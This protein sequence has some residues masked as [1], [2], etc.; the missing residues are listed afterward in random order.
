MTEHTGIDPRPTLADPDDDP[1]RWLEEVE[2]ED[3]LAWVEAQNLATRAAYAD[4]LFEADRDALKAILDRPDNIPHVARR[5]DWLYNFW[6]DGANPRGIWRRTTMAEFD[7]ADPDWHIL[8]DLDALAEKEKADWIWHGASTRPGSHD[9]AILRLSTGGSDAVALREFDI[10]AGHFIED[11]FNLPPAKSMTHW[12]DRD[13]LLL[14]T[15]MGD[16][17]ATQS[18]YARTVR[19]WRH[20]Q[21]LADAAVIFEGQAASV[22]VGAHLSR[23]SAGNKIWL[24][25]V[26]SFFEAEIWLADK[27]GPRQKLDIP[28]DAKVKIH[29]DWLVVKPRHSWQTGGTEIPADTVVG[30]SLDAFLSGE[31]SFQV[32]FEPTE[33]RIVQGFT[34]FSDQL[35]VSI[36]DDLKPCF[37]VWTPNK[38]GWQRKEIAG[39]SDGGTANIWP[40]DV[41]ESESNGELLLM[42]Q[43]PVTPA[44]LAKLTVDGPPQV[45]KRQPPAFDATGLTVSR[46]EVLAADGTAIPYL[47][48]GPADD[49]LAGQAPVHLYG[50][51]GFGVSLLPNYRMTIGKLWLE[52]GGTSVIAN[53]RGGGEFGSA[54]HELGRHEGKALSHDDFAAVAKD[55]VDRGVTRPERIAAEG[56]SNGGLLITNMLTRHPARFGALFCT[57]PLVDMRRY[58][59]LLAGASWIDEY[60]DPDKPEDWAYLQNISAYHLARPG[61]GY[62]PILLAT[63][64]RDDRVH[65][66]HARKMA[67]KLQALGYDSAFYEPE[68][69]GHGYGKDNAETAAFVAL[70]YRF[71]RQAIG[72]ED[73]A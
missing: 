48:V 19:L 26:K 12:L 20:G 34:W 68:A 3:A 50:Y 1:F 60:G 38:E 61:E 59:K 18:G 37:E 39:L 10:E 49:P 41:E 65:P 56:G 16:G 15:P 8:L 64:R 70:G 43:D 63:S 2:G 22:L 5:G 35:L 45:L 6:R 52:K 7:K 66:G 9:R 62:P 71:L 4:T 54:W 73:P 72:W 24:S 11:G 27:T 25:E 53:L 69:G 28:T 36:L 46:H 40:L 58:S 31:R 23:G 21:D 55:L 67:A 29:P 51:G 44:N 47:Q 42:S 32:L 13:S 57:I 33:R 14:T 30:I 17:M